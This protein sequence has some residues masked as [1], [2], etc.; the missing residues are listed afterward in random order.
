MT[1]H[2]K[3]LTI[4][5]FVALGMLPSKSHSKEFDFQMPTYAPEYVRVQAGGNEAFYSKP[6]VFAAYQIIQGRE[7]GLTKQAFLQG[8]GF[9]DDIEM[10]RMG[11]TPVTIQGLVPNSFDLVKG[12]TGMNAAAFRVDKGI[13]AVIF[14]PD[15]D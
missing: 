5:L 11:G 14:Q 6:E 12:L 2:E 8:S 15:E 9:L 1:K 13:S 7:D 10:L 3:T 4:G